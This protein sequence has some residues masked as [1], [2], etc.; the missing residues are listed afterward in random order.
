VRLAV[1]VFLVWRAEY[2]NISNRIDKKTFG[3]YRG[4]RPERPEQRRVRALP[5]GGKGRTWRKGRQTMRGR[6][7]KT[8]SEVVFAGTLHNKATS[9]PD[10][11][12]RSLREIVIHGLA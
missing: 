6:D 10:S 8:V 7:D 2:R 9:R 1:K 4:R 5:D 12:N 3:P 11:D